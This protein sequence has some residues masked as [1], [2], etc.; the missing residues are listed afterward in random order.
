MEGGSIFPVANFPAVL[1][2]GSQKSPI[3]WKYSQVWNRTPLHFLIR[4]KWRFVY[5][6]SIFIS[7]FRSSIKSANGFVKVSCK[8]RFCTLVWSAPHKNRDGR[9]L[10]PVEGV[11]PWKISE[12]N[13]ILTSSICFLHIPLSTFST[14]CVVLHF[15]VFDRPQ[16]IFAS[17]RANGFS[18][19][20]R[21]L[22]PLT[23]ERR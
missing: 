6:L 20:P 3:C 14:F 16:V 18:S 5:V 13:T 7:G 22:C 8:F 17:N 21:S 11:W 1:E 2:S 9:L 15:L 19:A 10:F 12:P 4:R 23:R